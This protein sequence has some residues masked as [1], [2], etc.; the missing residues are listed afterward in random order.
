V[1]G[2]TRIDCTVLPAETLL[3][4]ASAG[5]PHPLI[6]RVINPA[7]SLFRSQVSSI[8]SDEVSRALA[9]MRGDVKRTKSGVLTEV[10]EAG[11]A[12]TAEICEMRRMLEAHSQLKV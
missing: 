9:A 7:V 3:T 11:Q 6:D 5:E 10:A 12:A 2:N 1:H 8:L 4:G